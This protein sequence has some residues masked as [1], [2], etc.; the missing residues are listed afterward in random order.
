[1]NCP[2]RELM[3]TADRGQGSGDMHN[4]YETCNAT[5][6]EVTCSIFVHEFESADLNSRA[7]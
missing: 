6:N 3:Q 4:R 7:V 2:K 1:M 5:P